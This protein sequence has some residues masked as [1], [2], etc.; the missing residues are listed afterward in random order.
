[1]NVSLRFA[2]VGAEQQRALMVLFVKVRALEGAAIS[3]I[4]LSEQQ[5]RMCLI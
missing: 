3:V 2:G 1:M 5:I 4:V